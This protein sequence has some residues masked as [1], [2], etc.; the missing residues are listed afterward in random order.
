MSYYSASFANMA[1]FYTIRYTLIMVSDIDAILLDNLLKQVSKGK[2]LDLSYSL[3]SKVNM[4]QN[5]NMHSNILA[6]LLKNPENEFSIEFVAMLRKKFKDIFEAT[7]I[8]EVSRE[9]YVTSEKFGSGRVDLAIRFNSGELLVIEN[10]IYSG[11]R[12]N[13]L[14]KYIDYY[15]NKVKK[16]FYGY[17]TLFD[18]KTPSVSSFSSDFKSKVG[19]R[20][21]TLSYQTDILDCINAALKSDRNSNEM[22]TAACMQ[23][24]MSLGELLIKNMFYEQIHNSFKEYLD[25]NEQQQE[26]LY[27]SVETMHRVNRVLQFFYLVMNKVKNLMQE[28]TSLNFLVNNLYYVQNQKTKYPIDCFDDFIN[29]VFQHCDKNLAFGI[30]CIANT[31]CDNV[32]GLGI[33][34]DLRYPSKLTI[35]IMRGGNSSSLNELEIKKDKWTKSANKDWWGYI[36]TKQKKDVWNLDLGKCSKE[37]VDVIGTYKVYNMS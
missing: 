35:G 23:Y 9:E 29:S 36:T 24:K 33:E 10:K 17:L 2:T 4:S 15:E 3:L 34:Y 6:M 32:N 26:D 14:N 21:R 31:T 37:F 16:V 25:L 19:E 20:F 18:E 27:N 30:V 28:S 22:F 5:E 7:K 12:D 13:Q 11:D 1:L 8:K